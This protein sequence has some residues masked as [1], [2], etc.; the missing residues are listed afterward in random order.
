MRRSQSFDQNNGF[1]LIELMIVIAVI[2]IL[3]VVTV[4]KY[5]TVKEQYQLESAAQTV[6]SEL[7]YARQYAMDSRK[8]VDVVLTEAEVQVRT[9]ELILDSKRFEAGV[10]FNPTQLENAWLA[11]MRDPFTNQS[12]GRGL[13]FDQRGFNTENGTLLLTNSSGRTIGVKIEE[14][15]GDLSIIWP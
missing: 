7:N 8:N 4:P 10:Q 9:T 2:G 5:H 3:A 11:D 14:K 1:T 12:L 13:T 6:I 15:T